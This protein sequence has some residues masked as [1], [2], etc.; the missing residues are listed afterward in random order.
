MRKVT[1]HENYKY[2]RNKIVT[3]IRLSKK[4]YYQNYFK[5]NLNNIKKTWN[6]IKQIINISNKI[7]NPI[8]SMYIN[9]NVS[10]EMIK[11]K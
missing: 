10:N 1:L 5:E 2:Y 3:L 9:N 11:P 8:T 4:N 7:F 6:G